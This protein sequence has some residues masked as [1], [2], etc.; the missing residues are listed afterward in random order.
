VDA[1]VYDSNGWGDAEITALCR[2]LE[3]TQ[4]AECKKI[5]LSQNDISTAGMGVIASCLKGGAVAAL[6][7]LHLHGN[8]RASFPSREAIREAKPGIAVHYDGMG[9]ARTNHMQ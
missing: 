5:W 6:E 7:D 9:G 2:T 8:P 1:L 4:L 3:G